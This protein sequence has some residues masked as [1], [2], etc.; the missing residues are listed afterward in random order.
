MT[1]EELQDLIEG[2]RE[3]VDNAVSDLNIELH[4][5]QNDVSF[6][7]EEIIGLKSQIRNLEN[8]SS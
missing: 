3:Y 4:K 6:L 5:T 2:L 8:A 7:Q 1:S